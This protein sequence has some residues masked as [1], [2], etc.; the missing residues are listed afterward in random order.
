METTAA[1]GTNAMQVRQRGPLE[2]T[3]KSI[4]PSPL[5]SPTTTGPGKLSAAIS[6]L[7][8]ATVVVGL[9]TWKNTTFEVLETLGGFA[10]VTEAVACAA[11]S[12]AVIVAVNRVLATKVV[13]RALPVHFTTGPGTNPVAFPGTGEPAP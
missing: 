13:L 3:A 6:V 5:K 4:F 7:L 9:V 12:A 1:G 8:K 11:M 10:T 2:T